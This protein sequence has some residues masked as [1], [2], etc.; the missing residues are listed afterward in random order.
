VKFCKGTAK[1]N[2]HLNPQKARCVGIL[3]TPQKN[4]K[5]NIVQALDGALKYVAGFVVTLVVRL[6][7]PLL[8]WSNISPL[9]ATQLAGSKAYGPIIGGLYGVLSMVLLDLL[10]GKVGSWTILTAISYGVVGIAGGYFLRNRAGSARNFVIVSVVGTL[11]F[12]LVT[13]VLAGPILFQQPFVTALVGQIPFTIRHLVGNVFFATV[14]A[15]WFYRAIMN[16]PSWDVS[17]L[18]KT[19]HA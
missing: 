3:I 7:T 4:M 19:S 11:F 2:H 12:D 1:I 6:V 18:L 10:V 13:G 9:M 16:N 14:L 15:P 17:R 5:N 8:G